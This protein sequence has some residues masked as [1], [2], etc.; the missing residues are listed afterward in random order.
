MLTHT[1]RCRI[2]LIAVTVLVLLSLLL[3]VQK[4]PVDVSAHAGVNHADVVVQSGDGSQRM[5]ANEG[6]GNIEGV[7]IGEEVPVIFWVYY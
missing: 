3:F 5:F 6:A 2:A 1:R 7:E 4:T